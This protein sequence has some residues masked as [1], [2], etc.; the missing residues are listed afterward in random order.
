L[1]LVFNTPAPPPVFDPVYR[2][3]VSWPD[4]DAL[5]IKRELRIFNA[6]QHILCPIP[7]GEIDK[8]PT[9]VQNPGW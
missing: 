8:V 4:G 1:G 7:Q 2:V 3:P 9:L 6:N 5:R